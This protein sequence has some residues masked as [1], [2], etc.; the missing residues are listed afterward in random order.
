MKVI[1]RLCLLGCLF[2]SL[3]ALGQDS[4]IDPVTKYID[5]CSSL[6][7]NTPMSDPTAAYAAGRCAG[8]IESLFR[9]SGDLPVG[10]RFCTDKLT[11]AFAAQA[12]VIRAKKFDSSHLAAAP[13][14]YFAASALHDLA[15]PPCDTK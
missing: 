6:A 1:K 3:P 13:F 15:P 7:V 10:A 9:F 4:P 8:A 12:I 14:A 2:V 11:I 5:G